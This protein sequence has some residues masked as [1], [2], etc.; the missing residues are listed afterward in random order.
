MSK[1]TQRPI[2]DEKMINELAKSVGEILKNHHQYNSLEDCIEDAKDVLEWNWNEDGFKLAK[3]FDDKGYNGSAQLVDDL[4]CVSS[5]ASDILKEAEKRWVK[6]NN[7]KLELE[8]GAQIVFDVYKKNN[9]SGEIVKLY[10]ETAQYGVWAESLKSR[11]GTSHY[12]IN[13]EKVKSTTKTT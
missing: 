9:E 10:P 7:I 13:F 6:E 2:F 5:D 12:I 11:K 1:I 3:E 4:D 8:I